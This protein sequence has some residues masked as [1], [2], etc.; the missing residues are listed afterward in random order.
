MKKA[1]KPI[2][3][4]VILLVFAFT[5][6]SVFGADNYFGEKRIIYFKD[7]SDIRL[8]MDAGGG[9]QTVY[10]PE[11]ED[12][13]VPTME[14]L[15]SVKQKLMKRMEYLRLT[16]YD[17]SINEESGKLTVHHQN[18]D[19]NEITVAEAFYDMGQTGFVQI[20]SGTT[21]TGVLVD[22]NSGIKRADVM[23]DAVNGYYIR[24]YFTSAGSDAMAAGTNSVGSLSVWVDGENVASPSISE[25]VTNGQLNITMQSEYEAY[26]L[27]GLMNSGSLPFELNTDTYDA[28]TP[29]MGDNVMLT[30]IISAGVLLAAAIIVLIV[31]YKLPGIA[32]SIALIGQA[33]GLMAVMTGFFSPV[34][35]IT[36]TLPVAAAILI[37]M[38]MGIS[39]AMVTAS[40]IK[41]EINNDRTIDG[42]VITG[43]QKA[44]PGLIGSGAVMVIIAIVLMGAFGFGH[45]FTARIFSNIFFFGTPVEGHVYYFAYVLFGGVLFSIFM[46]AIVSRIILRGLSGFKALRR[47]SLYGGVNND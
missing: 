10:T 23:Y 8:G 5:Y 15:E 16:D 2:S 35:S 28:F 9:W 21:N 7:Y 20:C 46:N 25:A 4:I 27:A 1:G 19:N 14:E 39:A 40:N 11:T 24:I 30:F 29:T 45:S 3:I 31:K 38:F 43:Y 44:L 41:A 17:I 12:G 22:S 32:A 18:Y 26:R 13:S 47:P 33:A 42:A 37:S 36:F 6:F 34:N